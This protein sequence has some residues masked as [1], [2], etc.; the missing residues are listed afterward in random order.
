MTD[1]IL[2]PD[3]C[4]AEVAEY[5]EQIIP[6]YKNNPFIEVLPPLLTASEVIEK[7]AFYP[8]YNV[9]E[10]K[11]DS[12]HRIHLINR[13][14]QV[15]QPLPMNI[16]LESRISR[17]IRQGYI[18]RNPF[19]WQLAQ[20]FRQDY[21]H[22]GNGAVGDSR[23]VNPSSSGFT[24]LGVSGLGKTSALNHILRLYPQVIIHKGY[25]ETPLSTYQV[26][27][28]K[29]EC[30][31]DGSIKG[32]L[33][34]FFSSIDRLLGTNYHKK[35]IKT[36]PTTDMMLTV[37]NQVVRNTNLGLLVI[38]EIQHLS[39]AKSGGSQKM[40]NF[41]VN[42]VNNVGLPVI[43]VGTPKA[44]GVLQGEFRKARRGI[45]IDGDMICDRLK[46]DKV[47]N[48]LVQSI[49]HYQWTKK[50]I[51]LTEEL[52]DTLYDETQG[53][54]DLLIK[55]YATAQAYAISSGKEDIAPNIL[56]KV[57]KEN[58]QLV[59][60]MIKALRSGSIRE[61]AKYEDVYIPNIDLNN[62]L[63]TTKEKI[64]LNFA[65]EELL[66]KIKEKEKDSSIEETINK[67][68]VI[69]KKQSKR[70]VKETREQINPHDIRY[71]VQQGEK[72]N[73]SAYE[74]LKEK[75]YIK[76]FKDD[77]FTGGVI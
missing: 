42:L 60:P 41:F 76:D 19:G 69:N 12:H 23:M 74:V 44:M 1:R 66:N 48:L 29:L 34:D 49:W 20:G 40:L 52:I 46:K 55:L 64:K 43:M 32:L 75:G 9:E 71:I 13:I 73:K 61:M 5:K 6:D 72:D 45:G 30:P 3:G 26:V 31:Y 35:M 63:S 53:I 67:E 58:L 68:A 36:R 28:L 70:K 54:P 27:W 10:R 47:W 33:Y 37:M 18:T 24:L 14:F 4:S 50:E 11:L 38:D 8:S 15:F 17:S 2:I 39:T 62:V 56:K 25:Y 65:A 57:A 7:L 22:L 51:P 21:E 16:K 59:Q 77:I